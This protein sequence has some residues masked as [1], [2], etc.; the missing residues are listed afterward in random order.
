M[1]RPAPVNPILDPSLMD[2]IH[3]SPG[4]LFDDN[5]NHAMPSWV[6]LWYPML[7]CVTLPGAYLHEAAYMERP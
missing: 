6:S 3:R 7:W 5:W 4:G 2:D 1:K